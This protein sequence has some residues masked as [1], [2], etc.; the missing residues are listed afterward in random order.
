MISLIV[1]KA[2]N[3]V[4]GCDNQLPWHLP[5]DLKHFKKTT[6]GKPIIMGRKTFE[7][8]GRV[9]PGRPHV[10]IS[11]NGQYELPEG[12]CHLV[13][14]LEAGIR[15]AEE[16]SDDAV[17]I[18]GAEIY[19]QAL[20]FVDVLYITEVHLK[21]EGDATFPKLNLSIWKE[22]FREDHTGD[23]DFSFVQYQRVT[24]LAKNNNNV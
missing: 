18:G 4:I 21:P 10:V 23:I 9:L 19:Q 1:A 11:R 24:P 2:D 22:V 17:I 12:D 7:S 8:L 16:L 6:L 20:E 3:Q 14:S 5:D 15:L 13:A